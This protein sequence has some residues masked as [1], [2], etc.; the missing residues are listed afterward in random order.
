MLAV[1]ELANE[2]IENTELLKKEIYL[3][4]VDECC[5][6]I[7]KLINERNNIFHIESDKAIKVK[8][9]LNVTSGNGKKV[10]YKNYNVGIEH[11]N[12]L[13]SNRNS[14]YRK[15]ITLNLLKKKGFVWQNLDEK[16]LK[17]IV[18]IANKIKVF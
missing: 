12:E 2:K 18:D 4:P 17:N 7:L 11:L 10:V 15:D 6:A 14:E 1:K 5:K 8:Q 13:L 16:Y 9:I 3:T